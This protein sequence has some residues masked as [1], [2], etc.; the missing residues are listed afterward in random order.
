MEGQKN[1]YFGKPNR[2]QLRYL[3][4]QTLRIPPMFSNY[5]LKSNPDKIFLFFHPL[6]KALKPRLKIKC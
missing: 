3:E 1:I 4:K 6:V 5:K 2:I